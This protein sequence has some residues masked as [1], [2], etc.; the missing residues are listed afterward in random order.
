VL[1]CHAVRYQKQ[2]KY[3]AWES[4]L[5]GCCVIG[6]YSEMAGGRTNFPTITRQGC[7]GIPHIGDGGALA[8]RRGREKPLPSSAPGKPKAG[9]LY[10]P[11][12]PESKRTNEGED[13]NC[14]LD[15]LFGY[16]LPTMPYGILILVSDFI[17]IYP[18]K[19]LSTGSMFSFLSLPF[20]ACEDGDCI[21]TPHLSPFLSLALQ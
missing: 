9:V 18:A 12:V 13:L 20:F 5:L 1:W 14:L 15:Y 16:H 2:Y 6:D 3:D 19:S 8:H 21:C 11:S 7:E 4:Q 17:F 10:R